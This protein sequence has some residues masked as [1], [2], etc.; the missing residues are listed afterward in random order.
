MWFLIPAGV[1]LDLGSRLLDTWGVVLLVPA[2][3]A[4]VH[5]PPLTPRHAGTQVGRGEQERD[6]ISFATNAKAFKAF[7][8]TLLPW[9]GRRYRT[10]GMDVGTAGHEKPRT[11]PYLE[12]PTVPLRRPGDTQGT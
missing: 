12:A 11:G 4:S 1:F 2:G 5:S 7:E 10:P 6:L 3:V 9:W 8:E